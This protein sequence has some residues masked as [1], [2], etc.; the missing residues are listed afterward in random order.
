MPQTFEQIIEQNIDESLTSATDPSTTDITRLLADAVVCT[1]NAIIGVN[2][3]E[4]VKFSVS[5]EDASDSGITLTGKLISVIREHDSTSILRP[6]ELIEA[7]DRY[8]AT[9][10]DSLHYRSKYNPGFYILNGKIHTVPSSAGSDNSAIVS[11]VGYST[12]ESAPTPG[13][14]LDH[15]STG[16]QNFPDEY[17]H[18]V[19][20][21]VTAMCCLMKAN[22]E[23]GT[24]ESLMQDS[25]LSHTW[26]DVEIPDYNLPD[27]ESNFEV[28]NLSTPSEPDD[29]DTSDL[30]EFDTESFSFGDIS[31]PDFTHPELPEFS[32]PNLDFDISDVQAQLSL[33]DM[34]LADKELEI[35]SKKL[36]AFTKEMDRAKEIYS[37]EN[38]IYAKKFEEESKE[39][40]AGVDKAKQEFDKEFQEKLAEFQNEFDSFKVVYN[41]S[42]EKIKLEYEGDK[43]NDLK[44]FEAQMQV[45]ITSYQKNWERQAIRYKALIDEEIAEFQAELQIRFKNKEAQMALAIQKVQIEQQDK[46]RRMQGWTQIYT[47]WVQQYQTFMGQFVTNVQMKATVKPP[48]QQQ[49]QQDRRRR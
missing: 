11:Q 36:E 24:A 18:L 42:W 33:E 35:V 21:Y 48:P 12:T 9:D 14:P 20:L 29:L 34:E 4:A 25:E 31:L 13:D 6:C 2:P 26:E 7:N 40:E 19:V 30:P 17:E 27:F 44:M 8:N 28:G 38:D 46:T 3:D 45:N 43:Q 10:N 49:Q 16:I 39:Y 41:A 32:P 23:A 47:W 37:T 1:T 22:D 5:T 15:G